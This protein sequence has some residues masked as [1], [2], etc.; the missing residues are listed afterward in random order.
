MRIPRHHQSTGFPWPFCNKIS[1]AR[2]SGVPHRVYVLPSIYLAKPK[3]VSF[4]Y[5]CLSIRR[6]SGLLDSIRPHFYV[7]NTPNLNEKKTSQSYIRILVEAPILTDLYKWY[8]W[9]EGT[10]TWEWPVPRKTWPHR[11]LDFRCFSSGWKALHLEC[12]PSRCTNTFHF[13]INRAFW[14]S[15][16]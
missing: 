2:Y 7:Q 1:G 14:S 12:S 16:R 4:R 15:R 8:P 11:C 5:P 9:S 6:F 13:V 10:R 3:S